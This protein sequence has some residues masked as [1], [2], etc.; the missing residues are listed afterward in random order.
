MHKVYFQSVV[1]KNNLIL[2]N[3][4]SG[5]IKLYFTDIKSHVLKY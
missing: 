3:F 5:K 2:N 1:K 4:L